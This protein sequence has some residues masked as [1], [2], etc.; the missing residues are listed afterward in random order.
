[1]E[2]KQIASQSTTTRA[3]TERNPCVLP[4][5]GSKQNSAVPGT[6]KDHKYLETTQCSYEG[7]WIIEEIWEEILKFQK[8]NEN[9]NKTT[10]LVL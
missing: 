5:V 2:P 9:K 7:H 6:S 4:T 3:H 1:M 10:S 8:S